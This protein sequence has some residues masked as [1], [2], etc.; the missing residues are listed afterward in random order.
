MDTSLRRDFDARRLNLVVNDPMVKPYVA[1]PHQ[2]DQEIDLTEVVRDRRNIALM[3][4]HGGLL[5]HWMEPGIY[6]VHTQFTHAMR[7]EPVLDFTEAALSWMF[8][9]TGAMELLTK[10]PVPNVAAAWLAQKIGGRLEFT[11]DGAWPTPQGA[12]A[13]KYYALRWPDWIVRAKF[14]AERGHEFHEW[15]TREKASRGLGLA[16]HP[17]DSFHDQMVGATVEMFIHGQIDKAVIL[18]NR[19]ARFAG[20]MPI[21]VVEIEPAS[22]AVVVDISDGRVVVGHG[23]MSWVEG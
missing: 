5:F 10:V 8:L 12:V 14:L 22:G 19:W 9:R 20:Y 18:Y 13:V 1:L 2:M 21:Q 6:E 15:L 23:Q 17:D 4:D 16:P 3:C 11:R 7:G